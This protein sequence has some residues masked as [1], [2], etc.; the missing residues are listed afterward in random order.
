MLVVSALNIISCLISNALSDES[1]SGEE[2]SLIL[3]EFET[4]TRMKE[5]LRR[6]S[7]TSPEKSGNREIEAS[8]VFNRNTTTIPT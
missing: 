7:K 1:I 4:I 8:V 3:L 6:R 5:E 2:Y